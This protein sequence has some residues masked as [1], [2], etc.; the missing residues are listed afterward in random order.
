LGRWG[1]V[2]VAP[3]LPE[4]REWTVDDLAELP[5]DLNYELINGRLVLPS[6]TA[7][8]QD[9]CV[10]VLLAIEANCPP[11]VVPIIDLSLKI[12]RR[13][14]PRP[15]VVVISTAHYGVSPVPVEDAVLAVEVLSPSSTFRDLHEKAN[16]YARAGVK[17]Y[18]VVD[19][20]RAE[21]SLT[22][23]VLD[24]DRRDY[25]PRAHTTEMFETD[26]PW[27]ITLDLPALTARRD[28]LLKRA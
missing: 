3:L 21:M 16:V 14:E 25:K 15:D 20:L 17:I 8:H 27:S 9:T 6:P 13:N 10:R 1:V 19:A 18:W 12:D 5:S 26:D 28:A 7:M 23:W 11:D 2:T 4:R 24:E 22:E